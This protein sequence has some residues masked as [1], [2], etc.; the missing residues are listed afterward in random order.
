MEPPRKIMTFVLVIIVSACIASSQTWIDRDFSNVKPDFYQTIDKFDKHYPDGNP[1]KGLGWKPFKRLEH[2]WKWRVAPGDDIPDPNIL[3]KKWQNYISGQKV[4]DKTHDTRQWNFLGPTTKPLKMHNNPQPGVGRINCIEIHPTNPN[5]FWAGAATGGIWKTT[6]NGVNWT[7]LPMTDFMSI[8]ISDI[9]VSES[10]PNTIYAATG[11]ADAGGF[12]GVVWGFSIGIIKSIDGGSTWTLTN[13]TSEVSNRLLINRLLV[14]PT[15]P[16]TVYAASNAGL[17]FSSD[18]GNNWYSLSQT[19]C[20]DIEFHS[21]NHNIIYAS[22]IENN[23]YTFRKYDVADNSWSDPEVFSG[24]ARM[25]LAVAPSNGNYVYALSCNSQ[26]GFH[27]V[28]KS[29]DGGN[30]WFVIADQTQHPNYLHQYYDGSGTGGQ[31]IYDLAIAVSPYSPNEV[32]I[33]GINIWK[34][35]DGG[36]HWNI[37]AEWTGTVAEFVHADQ[38]ALEFSRNGTLYAGHDGG[39]SFTTDRGDTWRDISDGLQITQF[40]RLSQSA[41]NKNMIIAGSQDNGTSKYTHAGWKG[42]NGGDG[43]DNVVDYSNDNYVYTSIYYGTFYKSTDGGENFDAFISRGQVNE[44]AGWVAPMEIDPKD[45]AVL[46]LGYQNIWKITGRGTNGTRISN[47]PGTATIRDIAIAPSDPNTI[48]V[49]KEWD[50]ESY[51]L[52]STQNGGQNWQLLLQAGVPINDVVFEPTDPTHFWFLLGSYLAGEKVFEVENNEVVNISGTLP[53]ISYNCLAYQKNSP[54]RLYLGSDAGVFYFDDNM[55]DWELYGEGLP[56]VIVNDLAI[57]YK[58]GLM[59]AATYGRGLWEIKINDCDL[60]TPEISILGDTEICEGDSV[61]LEVQGDY[62]SYEWS[63]GETGSRIVVKKSGAYS[64]TVKDEK[65]CE[66]E[67][68]EIEIRVLSVP[69]MKVNVRGGNPFCE[70]D[71]VQLTGSFVFEEFL[72][73]TGETT[74]SIFVSEPGNY[75][76]IGTYSNGCKDESDPVTLTSIPSPPKPT[77]TQYDDKLISSEAYSYQWYRDGRKISDAVGR[78]HIPELSGS[79]SVEAGSENGCT[80]MSDAVDVVVS[81]IFEGMEAAAFFSIHP[82][83]ASGSFRIDGF[84]ASGAEVEISNIL[85]VRLMRI[86]NIHG[87][88]SRDID[89]ELYE[90]G[91]YFVI[92]K[93]DGEVITKKLVLE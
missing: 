74:R 33:G 62:A 43:M 73:S 54:D 6:N 61:I 12:F 67:S 46:Y 56:R 45:P 89:M 11:D 14:D 75:S 10:R 23:A 5:I 65:D 82:N 20:R 25:E 24:A 34:S 52:Y 36:L 51:K 66:A 84:S 40:Y 19:Y 85:G 39:I 71:T 37:S 58:E 18:G 17:L 90:S 48:F 78:E 32:F 2:F 49:S 83:P 13:L 35:I 50:G 41:D 60:N 86:P 80:K 77:I 87:K 76:C 42:I 3:Y 30:N 63:N 21:D 91:I 53:N 68:D 93:V 70:G 27:S 79:Y 1:G 44:N 81:T 28:R 26:Q 88:F 7:S 69:D 22:L 15:D 4:A 31:G 64:C 38:H 8:G 92:M 47:F 55:N 57:F 9:A 72:W 16:N 59:R 29:T